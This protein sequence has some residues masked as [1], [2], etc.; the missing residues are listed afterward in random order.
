MD[1]RL[2]PSL[3]L[4]ALAACSNPPPPATAT[5]T[6]TA[7][8]TPTASSTAAALPT[9][10]PS[11]SPTSA[12]DPLVGKAAPDFTATAQDGT[13]VHVAALKG[14]AVVVYFYPKDETPGCTKEACSFRD[15][16]TALGKTGAVLVGV[17]ADGIDSHKAFAAHYK[18]PF[19]LVSDPDGSIGKSYG[20][21]F[22]G[23]HKRQTIVIGSDGNVRKV[24]RQV[25]V[26]VHAQQIL[27]DLSHP[28]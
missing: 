12:A 14:K 2:L 8:A 13:S 17:S 5:A 27:D 16:W 10:P 3:A 23:Y 11:A 15:A 22:E 4:A 18:L 28:S 24:Y 26:G 1:A 21:P 20:V 19:L 6:Q 7:T 9:P 25:D